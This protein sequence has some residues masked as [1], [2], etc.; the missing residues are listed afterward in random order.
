MMAYCTKPKN[1]TPLGELDATILTFSVFIWHPVFNPKIL[2]P[3]T[4]PC[5]RYSTLAFQIDQL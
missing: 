5:Y 2:F 4:F 1:E 3:A